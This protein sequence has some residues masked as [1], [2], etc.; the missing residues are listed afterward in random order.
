M[1]AGAIFDVAVDLRR[2]SSGFGRYVGA[3][4]TGENRQLCRVPPGIARGFVVWTDRADAL[5]KATDYWTPELKRSIAWNDPAIGIRW[6]VKDE[7]ILSVEDRQAK[8]LAHA[9]HFA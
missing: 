2:I 5:Y 6:P 3:E 7:P 9:E 1:S 4:L 8:L